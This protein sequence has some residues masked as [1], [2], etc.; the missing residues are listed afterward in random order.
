[1]L[2]PESA[3]AIVGALLAAAGTV[4]QLGKRRLGTVDTFSSEIM[5]KIRISAADGYLQ[6]IINLYE[7]E[8]NRSGDV[9]RP[10]EAPIDPSS[11]N[12]FELF[13]HR[14]EDLSSLSPPV[15]DYVT[16]YYTF[17]MAARDE[18]GDL[19]QLLARPDLDIKLL[20][21]QIINVVFMVDIVM[22]SA[23]RALDLLIEKG[24]HK[25]HAW[26][27]TC[28]VGAQANNFVRMKISETD[29]RYSEVVR[30]GAHYQAYIK[31]LNATLK[32]RRR[33]IGLNKGELFF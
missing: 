20:R 18:V 15:V 25:W 3:A 9:M 14:S 2:G 6:R 16:D 32:A 24:I 12:P 8:P 13:Y 27:L 5:A 26:H 28:Y 7:D 23:Y 11:E 22:L 31:K 19:Q 29:P 10:R 4:Y 17:L 21:A 33:S 30:R 1:V